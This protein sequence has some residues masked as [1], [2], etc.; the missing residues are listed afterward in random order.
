MLRALGLWR[1]AVGL[2]TATDMIV[3]RTCLWWAATR[4]GTVTALT[5]IKRVT[6]VAAA[7]SL[8]TVTG[9]TAVGGHTR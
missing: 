5:T 1:V 7:T 8:K 2:A 3:G 6:A 4:S 9:V